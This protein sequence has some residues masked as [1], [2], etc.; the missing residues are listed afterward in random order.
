MKK[1]F[2]GSFLM[3]ACLFSLTPAFSSDKVMKPV[4]ATK[5]VQASPFNIP[6]IVNGVATTL[7]ITDFVVRNG[8]IVALGTIQ[9]VPGLIALPITIPSATCDILHLAVG[10]IHLDLLGLVVDVAPINIDIV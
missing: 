9:S 1:R 5:A 6:A 2:I 7:T 3:A 4:V 10:A 8:Q